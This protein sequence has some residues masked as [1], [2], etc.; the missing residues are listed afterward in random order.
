MEKFNVFVVCCT[1]T[2]ILVHLEM[3]SCCLIFKQE[4]TFDVGWRLFAQHFWLLFVVSHSLSLWT[5]ILRL[6]LWGYKNISFT[7][8]VL[9]RQTPSFIPVG[10]RV[11]LLPRTIDKL[12]F[13]PDLLI[14]SVILPV[15]VPT[16]NSC[17][18]L[19]SRKLSITVAVKQATLFKWGKVAKPQSSLLT[20]CWS[21]VL[22]RHCCV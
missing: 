4:R 12:S 20:T 17:C 7:C 3:K 13:A 21:G 10:A 15:L 11:N 19:L 1:V 22:G 5:S 6:I 2:W 18:L 16:W 8:E 9:W 14:F